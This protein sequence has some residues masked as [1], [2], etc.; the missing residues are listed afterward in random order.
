MSLLPSEENVVGPAWQSRGM[1][2]SDRRD[3]RQS[4]ESLA[5]AAVSGRGMGLP[6]PDRRQRGAGR[7][8]PLA[9]CLAA[10]QGM[11]GDAARHLVVADPEESASAAAEARWSA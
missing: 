6:V 2:H 11:L 3:A 9:A 8:L 5:E 4:L 7:L 10:R 1:P